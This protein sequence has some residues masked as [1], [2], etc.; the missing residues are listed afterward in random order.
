M[1]W[2]IYSASRS[3]LR[4]S[5]NKLPKMHILISWLAT[6]QLRTILKGKRKNSFLVQLRDFCAH[7]CLPAVGNGVALAVH[8]FA[9]W[10]KRR[11]SAVLASP[12]MW[13][14]L[15]ADTTYSRREEKKRGK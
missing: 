1:G 6:K 10:P 14:P 12:A 3:V 15:A 11:T 13:T 8:R 2:F 5:Y 4:A 7:L 9:S